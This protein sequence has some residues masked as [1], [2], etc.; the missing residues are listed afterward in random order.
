MFF[1]V[2]SGLVVLGSVVGL[3]ANCVASA[4]K[5]RVSSLYDQ[6]AAACN[7]TGGQTPL[8]I[9]IMNDTADLNANAFTSQSVQAATEAVTLLLVTVGFVVVVSW[10]VAICRIA[11][12][13]AARALLTTAGGI[14][15]TQEMCQANARLGSIIADTMEAAADQRRR[16]TAAC[17]IV[18]LTFPIRATY[19]LIFAYSAFQD[20]SVT[21]CDICGSCQ[22]VPFLINVYLVYTPELQPIIVALSSPLPLTLSLWLITKAHERARL[23]SD[24]MRR[25]GVGAVL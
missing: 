24:S 14:D 13:V 6:V 20:P 19:G 12:R 9:Q 18:L 4:F 3:V 16:L 15:M 11:E 5:T 7:S 25:A 1:K 8:S 10:S 2:M 23:I 17:I 21:S 22:T